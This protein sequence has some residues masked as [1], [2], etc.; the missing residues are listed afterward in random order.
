[1][2]GTAGKTETVHRNGGNG[3]VLHLE[4]DAGVNGTTLVF[5]NGKNGA[6]DQ[7][8]HGRLGDADALAGVDIG[9]NGVVIG[10]FGRN[11]EG[12][13][14]GADGHLVIIVHH[15]SDGTFRQ[16][17]DDVAK[18]AGGQDAGAAVGH[19]GFDLV[20][21]GGFH[22]VAGEAQADGGGTAEDAFDDGKTALC[23][24]G[25]AGDIQTSGQ[26]AFFTG[27]THSGHPFLIYL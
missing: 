27:K 7:F 2:E 9:Q 24:H 23:S 19:I 17:A 8:L 22:I 12:S 3:S 10:T 18:K 4:L 21:D 15:N 1:M 26:H 16:T 13:I 11:I 6:G 14:A 20:G 25:T 5:R